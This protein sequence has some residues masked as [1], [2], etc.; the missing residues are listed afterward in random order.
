MPGF[1]AAD[2]AA[3]D[4]TVAFVSDVA[5]VTAAGV[6]LRQSALNIFG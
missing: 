1:V 4:V 2:V 6:V 3:F 5:A